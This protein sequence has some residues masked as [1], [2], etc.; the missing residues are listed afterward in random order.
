MYPTIKDLVSRISNLVRENGYKI[1]VVE[2]CTGGLISS[3]LTD[4]MGSSSYFETGFILYSDLSKSRNFSI[5]Q[6]KIKKY[7]PVSK[8]ITIEL[9]NILK[10]RERSDIS[11]AVTGYLGPFDEKINIPISVAHIAISVKKKIVANSIKVPYEDRQRSKMYVVNEVLKML[12][13]LF[14][15]ER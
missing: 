8:E 10:E 11:I 1:S 5:S 9:L 2:S 13:D 14:E 15:E 12:L 7:G 3:S 6:D 4:I